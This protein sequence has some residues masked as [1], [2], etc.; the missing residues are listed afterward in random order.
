MK[1]K[2]CCLIMPVTLVICL[3]TSG[4]SS[5]SKSLK[6]KYAEADYVYSET[7]KEAIATENLFYVA[8]NGNDANP[9][10]KSQ[11]WLTIRKAANTLRS[12]QKAYVKEG[13]YNERITVKNSGTSGKYIIF[14]AYPNHQVIIDGTGIAP[15]SNVPF[16]GGLFTI[17][18]QNY[19]IVKGFKIRNS[20]A[21]GIYS[22]STNHTIIKNNCIYNTH[23][24]GIAAYNCTDLTIAGNE[25]V[26]ATKLARNENVLQCLTVINSAAFEVKNNVIHHD[27]FPKSSDYSGGEGLQ[28]GQGSNNGKI[29]QNI[30]HDIGKV[31]LYLD[32]WDAATHNIEVYNNQV[33]RCT[34]MG[35]ACG[36]EKGGSL[37]NIKI[38]N[39]LIYN[40]DSRGIA[41]GSWGVTGYSHVFNNI[42]IYNNTIYNNQYL[43]NKWG[44]GI[45]VAAPEGKNIY[46][47]NNICYKNWVDTVTIEA[48][49]RPTNPVIENNLEGNDPL[50]VAPGSGNF[51]LQRGSPAIDAAN[52]NSAPSVDFDGTA[53]PKGNGYDI[54]AF[55][56]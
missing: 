25:I 29:Y 31:G 28:V 50:F 10:T 34:E 48:D 52:S 21:L 8:K 26:L 56:Y 33:Y 13:I 18:H 36:A 15:N 32:A 24:A 23:S 2:R 11:P 5:G 7:D 12:G 6:T 42:Y 49:G 38:Y 45:H 1:K 19:I 51:H 27:G 55:E 3:L 47:R 39:N 46:I 35:L 54:G 4:C 43:G 20:T 9:G 22:G 14:S 53:R 30:V 40:N 41:V 17:N 16:G 37:E 44:Y